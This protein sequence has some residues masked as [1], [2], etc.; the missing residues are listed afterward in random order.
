MRSRSLLA[1]AALVAVLVLAGCGSSSS[2]GGSDKGDA[3]TTTAS[4]DGTKDGSATD[5]TSAVEP[6]EIPAG[7]PEAFALPEGATVTDASTLDMD[8]KSFVVKAKVEDPEAAYEAY[9]TQVAKAGYE[10]LGASFTPSDNGG[11]GGFSA[12]GTDYTA[13]VTFGPDPTGSFSTLTVDVAPAT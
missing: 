8:S 9:K 5:V 1:A 10:V 2:D 6:V 11:F 3:T 13:A 12:R 7:F 4:N